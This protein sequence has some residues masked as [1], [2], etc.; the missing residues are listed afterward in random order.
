MVVSTHVVISTSPVVVQPSTLVP[1]PHHQPT[2]MHPNGLKP[3]LMWTYM[4]PIVIQQPVHFA[5]SSA[6]LQLVRNGPSPTIVRHPMGYQ[7]GRPRPPHLYSPCRPCRPPP[8][9]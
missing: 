9:I 6:Q 2:C 8:L 7:H 4:S 5:F 1:I 3:C